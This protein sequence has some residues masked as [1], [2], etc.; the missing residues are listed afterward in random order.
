LIANDHIVS[1]HGKEVRENLVNRAEF[2]CRTQANVAEKEECPL[3]RTVLG[4]PRRAFI[5]HVSRHME[6]IALTALPKNT[7]DDSVS[8]SMG[9][10]V[11]PCISSEDVQ[12]PVES[13]AHMFP[14]IKS[15][16][17]TGP[18]QFEFRTLLKIHGT[19]WDKIASFMRS[20]TSQMVNTLQFSWA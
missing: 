17:W 8:S 2:H 4:K 16:Y 14:P 7:E 10:D 18:E 15:N 9:S 13:Q 11:S 6:E 3:C 1:K 19:D 12:A 5:R 20:K